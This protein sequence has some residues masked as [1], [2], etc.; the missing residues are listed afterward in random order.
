MSVVVHANR[1]KMRFILQI[2]DS[3][4]PAILQFSCNQNNYDVIV[5]QVDGTTN[6][7][8]CKNGKDT[9]NSTV[10]RFYDWILINKWNYV[11]GKKEGS[12]ITYSKKNG[13]I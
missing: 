12:M 6:K 8:K 4:L 2:I 3:I 11:N 1:L 7:F 5:E 13:K 9:L 10:Y